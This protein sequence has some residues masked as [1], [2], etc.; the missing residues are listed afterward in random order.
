MQSNDTLDCPFPLFPSLGHA[1][2]VCKAQG[3]DFIAYSAVNNA[4]LVLDGEVTQLRTVA[5]L[6]CASAF[7]YS[8]KV[9]QILMVQDNGE[10][11]PLG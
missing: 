11:I 3:H 7:D 2:K 5:G 9:D 6:Q 1:V 4:W 10:L 8:V